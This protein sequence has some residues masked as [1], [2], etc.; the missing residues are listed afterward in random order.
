MK[1]LIQAAKQ[2]VKEERSA[3]GTSEEGMLTLGGVIAAFGLGWL[4]SHY[5]KPT[6][7]N[8]MSTMQDTAD[9]G[10]DPNTPPP[11]VSGWGQ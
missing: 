2:W 1:N 6:G 3:K 8:I 10:I 4:I 5:L 9:T 11:I 7:T